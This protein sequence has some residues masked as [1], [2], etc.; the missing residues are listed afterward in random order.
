MGSLY[1]AWPACEKG[2]AGVNTGNML[3]SNQVLLVLLLAQQDYKVQGSSD[4][5]L[6]ST[7][8]WYC[9]RREIKSLF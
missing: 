6:I 1:K 5:L 8:F 4:S 2:R 7:A 3:I 9:I